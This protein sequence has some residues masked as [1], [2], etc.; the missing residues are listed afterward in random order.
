MVAENIRYVKDVEKLR[1][2][3]ADIVN[4][5]VGICNIT[6]NI[7]YKPDCRSCRVPERYD[8]KIEH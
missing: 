2:S 1:E 4:N 7:C 8:V 3:T 5:Y 6:K